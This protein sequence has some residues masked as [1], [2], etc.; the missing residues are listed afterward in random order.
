MRRTKLKIS[1]ISNKFVQICI[2]MYANLRRSSKTNKYWPTLRAAE[3]A[4]TRYDLHTL[5]LNTNNNIK[6]DPLIFKCRSDFTTL[7]IPRLCSS[8]ANVH[9]EHRQNRA[10]RCFTD[11]RSLSAHSNAPSTPVARPVG[12]RSLAFLSRPFPLL[13]ACVLS[14]SAM[15]FSVQGRVSYAAR[16]ASAG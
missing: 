16:T 4:V 11:S 2:A 5:K 12:I 8:A 9:T 6:E 13:F 15:V 14:L 1:V 10:G 7:S 3:V